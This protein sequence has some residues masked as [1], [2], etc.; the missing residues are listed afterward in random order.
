MNATSKAQ[1][2]SLTRLPN[3]E[4]L[5]Q[6]MH[7]ALLRAHRDGGVMAV[8]CFHV[9]DIA[10]VNKRFGTAAGDNLL[11]VMAERLRS[12]VRATDFAGRLQGDEFAVVLEGVTNE[13][14]AEI[15]LQRLKQRLNESIDLLESELPV[16]V[17]GGIALY[18]REGD[19]AEK[20]LELALVKMRRSRRL[21]LIKSPA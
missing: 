21:T 9:E 20:L 17:N 3:R 5:Q 1:F 7:Y 6:Q 16:R 13:S 19:S 8:L 18:P 10:I 2:D 11:Q 12:G 15:I 4:L 14:H